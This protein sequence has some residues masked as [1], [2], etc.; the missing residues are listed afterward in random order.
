[1]L[2]STIPPVWNRTGKFTARPDRVLV[3][4][5][6]ISIGTGRGTEIETIE[7]GEL[8]R[9]SLTSRVVYEWRLKTVE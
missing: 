3:G 9:R 2:V 1:M 7:G 6:G 4:G 8:L 5:V